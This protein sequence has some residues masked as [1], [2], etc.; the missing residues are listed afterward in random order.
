MVSDKNL[1]KGLVDGP[2][3]CTGQIVVINPFGDVLKEGTE[4]ALCRCGESR[5]KPFCDGTD[6]IEFGW[7]IFHDPQ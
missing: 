5:N 1:V 3:L 6:H 7:R 4:I 2:L